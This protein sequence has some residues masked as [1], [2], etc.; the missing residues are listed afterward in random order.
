MMGIK[1]M[2]IYFKYPKAFTIVL[3]IIIFALIFILIL[4]SLFIYLPLL[5]IIIEF[6][7]CF[8]ST[9]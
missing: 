5:L 2:D 1:I 4:T 8:P 6:I 7:K 3:L 9:I